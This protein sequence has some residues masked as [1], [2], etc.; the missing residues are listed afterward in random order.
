MYGS[1]TN[2]LVPVSCC[3]RL[4]LQEVVRLREW[5]LL[6]RSRL[7]LQEV[8]A[9]GQ[10]LRAQRM[11]ESGQLLLDRVRHADVLEYLWWLTSFSDVL[12]WCVAGLVQCMSTTEHTAP[13][14]FACSC[15][16]GQALLFG[17]C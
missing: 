17:G 10:G 7:V 2:R 9:G 12:Y 11:A 15:S 8:M 5:R 3:S 4:V 1:G 16:K 6:S 13:T 14:T